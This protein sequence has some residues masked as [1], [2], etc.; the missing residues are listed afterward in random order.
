MRD[1]GRGI[2]V[3]YAEV[4]ESFQLALA[5]EEMNALRVFLCSLYA[6]SGKWGGTLAK[7]G[8]RRVQNFSLP[9]IPLER[10]REFPWPF[11]AMYPV[12][13]ALRRFGARRAYR[14]TRNAWFDRWAA[15][16]VSRE[17]D[18][19]MVVAVEGCAERTFQAA[20]RTGLRTILE[21]PNPPH[22]LHWQACVGAARDVGLPRPGRFDSD[23]LL[24]R[25]RAEL[26]AADFVIAI[27]ELQKR[28]YVRQGFP[29]DRIFTISL[30][31]DQRFARAEQPAK[32]TGKLKV[33]FVGQLGLH[34]GL[35]YLLMAAK[36]CE[37]SADFTL[38]GAEVAET[39]ELLR[40]FPAPVNWI[41][42]VGKDELARLYREHD[43]LVLP[44]LMETFGF[45]AMEAM[46][47][48]T[49]VI[50]TDRCGL[51]VPDETWRVPAMD[52]DALVRR[53]SYYADSPDDCR[54]DSETA[55]RFAAGFTPERY[56]AEVRRV[57]TLALDT[58]VRR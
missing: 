28:D 31:G 34:K 19:R 55:A 57:F 48:G 27:S 13:A 43:V 18:A 10:V 24:E 46:R 25:K 21:T 8:L 52:A 54:R 37:R 50:V 47:C 26:A 5:A 56:R 45:A 6:A 44:S 32:R 3:S 40:R 20:R 58:E 51:P 33:L 38:V 49:P 29:A 9:G 11:L 53:I 1:A 7:A 22:D 2:I 35:P 4:H 23:G 41:G 16:Q 42:T 36:R 14:G 30:W 39:R 12:A 15:A 17:K